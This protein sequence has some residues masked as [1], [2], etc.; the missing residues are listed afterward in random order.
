MPF[1][2]LAFEASAFS[3][4]L[5]TIRVASSLCWNARIRTLIAGVKDQSPNRWTTFQRKLLAF[6]IYTAWEMQ[7]SNLRSLRRRVYSPL[8]LP[9]CESPMRYKHLVFTANIDKDVCLVL[10][11]RFELGN[12]KEQFYRLPA[13]TA[14][15]RQEQAHTSCFW[16]GAED[17]NLDEPGQSRLY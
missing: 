9:L 2:I 14:C 4:T 15:I 7:D 12:P 1:G 13:L 8:Q 16:L 6:S 17:S 3:Q 10:P 5:P 11:P